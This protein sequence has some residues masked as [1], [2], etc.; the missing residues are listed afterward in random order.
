MD[1]H[2]TEQDELLELASLLVQRYT[3]EPVPPCRIC[4]GALSIASAGGGN[5]TRYACDMMEIDPDRPAFLRRKEGR[6]AADEH[7]SQSGWTQFN[8]GDRNVLDFVR[9]TL[10]SKGLKMPEANKDRA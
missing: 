10:E 6:F 9:M 4:G 1:A 8:P 5:A 2:P 7:Y 3:G